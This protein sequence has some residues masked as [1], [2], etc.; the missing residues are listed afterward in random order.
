MTTFVDSNVLVYANDPASD[1]KH[2]RAG[3]HLVRLWRD[4]SGVLS[5]QVLLESYV[6]LTRKVPNVLSPQAARDVIAA[7]GA[8]PLHRPDLDAVLA[9][10]DVAERHRISFWDALIVVSARAMGAQTLLTEDL[11]HGRVIEG[12]RVVNPFLEDADQV[13]VSG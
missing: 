1:D 9:A 10:S 4:G 2:A 11:Q 7:Y 5:T 8:W 12:V 6:N 3:V 13:G